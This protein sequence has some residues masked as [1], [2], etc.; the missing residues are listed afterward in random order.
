MYFANYADCKGKKFTDIVPQTAKNYSHD[1]TTLESRLKAK[2]CEAVSYTHLRIPSTGDGFDTIRKEYSDMLLSKAGLCKTER[3][4]C[5]TFTAVSYTHLDVYKRQ[6][7]KIDNAIGI[8]ANENKY[9]PIRDY[10]SS[11][12]WDGTER[13]CV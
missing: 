4:L 1:V 9:H 2:I 11:L 7:K 6:E 13:R 5:L 10:L 8:V 3:R 12:V